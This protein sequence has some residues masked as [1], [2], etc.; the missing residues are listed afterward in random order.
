MGALIGQQVCL[1]HNVKTR[2]WLEIFMKA[3]EKIYG[4]YVATSKHERDFGGE[5]S[6]KLCKP[7]NEHEK[8]P[9]LLG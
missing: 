3:I 7:W 2:L 4:V 1:D 8:R 5:N 9:L 6:C